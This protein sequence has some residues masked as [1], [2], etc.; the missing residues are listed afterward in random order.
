[1]RTR[2]NMGSRKVTVM[3]MVCMEGIR[4]VVTLATMEVA[5]ILIIKIITHIV[6]A[7]ILGRTKV[8]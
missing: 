8:T 1:M 7:I 6:V 2:S 5:C 3:D 4:T